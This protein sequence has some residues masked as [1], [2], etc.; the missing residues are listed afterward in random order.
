MRN[1]VSFFNAKRFY[2]A[3]QEPCI[4]EWDKMEGDAKVRYCNQCKLNVFN[5]SEMTDVEAQSLIPEV[6]TRL[7]VVMRQRDDG[8]VYTDNCPYKLRRLRNFLRAYA[9]VVLV[10]CAGIFAQTAADAQGLVGAPVCGRY[11]QSNEVGQLADYGY[12]AA[13]DCS[14]VATVFAALT[15]VPAGLWRWMRTRPIAMRLML[16]YGVS[17]KSVRA[18]IRKRWRQ[19][20]LLIFGVPLA[21]HMI[22]TWLINNWGG[23]GGGL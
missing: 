9:P 20:I 2:G 12:D 1:P 5:L 19:A 17:F 8:S 16:D 18:F 23:L 4:T 22:G 13:R 3:V 10:I 21:V 6:G 15:S 11:G 14:R 7:C